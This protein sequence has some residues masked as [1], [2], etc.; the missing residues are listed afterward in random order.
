MG[1]ERDLNRSRERIFDAALQEF[2]AHGFAGAR[3]SAIAR[4]AAINE[5]MIFHCFGSKEGLYREVLHREMARISTLL[6]SRDGADFASNLA[7]GYKAICANP[8]QLSQ[9]RMWQWEALEGK[10][11][12]L[13]AERERRAFLQ[14]EAAQL[15]R[16]KLRGELPQDLNEEM[17]LL[18]SI[19]LR[20]VPV[21]LPQ[22]ARLI[23]GLGED[24]PRF[25]RRWSKF[26]KTLGERIAT[27]GSA[28][29][30]IEKHSTS[31]SAGSSASMRGRNSTRRKSYG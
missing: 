31:S 5:Q 20:I 28:A 9:L 8:A 14:A 30:E 21:V 4:R 6:E 2:S 22:L 26:L 10:R 11:S 12:D 16:A 19:G 3:T 18:A 15:R 27:S 25:R 24:D 7:F 29:K 1:K 13:M 23:T 17:I